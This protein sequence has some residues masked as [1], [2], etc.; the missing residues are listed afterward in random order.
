MRTRIGMRA[1]SGLVVVGLACAVYAWSVIGA[2]A[3]PTAAGAAFASAY[4]YEYSSGHVTG[5]GSILGKSVQ[6]DFEAH[7][8]TKGLKGNCNV[9]E[10]K[11]NR[12]D[13]RSITS[14]VVVGTHAT[15]SGTARHNGV[16]TTFTIDIDDLGEPA[17]GLDQFAITT[18]TGY[19]RSGVLSSGNIQVHSH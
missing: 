2:F 13:C 10:G 12:V 16:E 7:A 1:A 4:Q 11:A 8:D 17:A 6:F 18:G 19:S 5:G 3:Q 9:K 14:L 15:F